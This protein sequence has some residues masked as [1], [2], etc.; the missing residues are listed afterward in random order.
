MSK[1]ITIV[2][3]PGSGKSTIANRLAKKLD[4]NL[5]LGTDQIR[6]IVRSYIPKEQDPVLHTSAILAYDLVNQEDPYNVRGFIAQSKSLKNGIE[7]IIRK[8]IKEDKDIILEGI[9]L[10]PEVIDIES[11]KHYE[12]VI[13]VP[14][15]QEYKKRIS[16]QGEQR[17]K[18]KLENID[19][20]L[21]FN[22]YLLNTKKEDTHIIKNDNIDR[23]VE[24]IVR[25]VT[26]S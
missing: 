12:F 10:I 13:T 14:D 25:I 1:I 6:E 20:A 26:T 11:D 2:G 21:D 19:K 9:H 8:T 4:I 16:G 24:E 18:Y 15:E 3:S 7:G 17:A 22:M 5:V 23:C